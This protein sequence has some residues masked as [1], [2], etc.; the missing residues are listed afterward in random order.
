MKESPEKGNAI[1]L[2]DAYRNTALNLKCLKTVTA[3]L[4]ERIFVVSNLVF[5]EIGH[6][7]DI[8]T[9]EKINDTILYDPASS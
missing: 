1:P 2:K 9:S 6:V 7:F 3:Y 4:P 5:H 8:P